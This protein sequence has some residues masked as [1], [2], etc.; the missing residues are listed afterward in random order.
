MDK[1][2]SFIYNI[3]HKYNMNIQEIYLQ[4]RDASNAEILNTL[5]HISE[6]FHTLSS[7][8][9]NDYCINF[10]LLKICLDTKLARYRI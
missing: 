5:F 10:L 9:K 4:L 8:E 2:K 6:L 3:M 1:Q 7:S